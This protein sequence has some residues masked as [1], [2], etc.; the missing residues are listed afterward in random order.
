LQDFRAICEVYKLKVATEK[1]FHIQFIIEDDSD[2]SRWNGKILIDHQELMKDKRK[3][4]IDGITY[5]LVK[6]TRP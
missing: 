1:Y 3:R 5:V 6:K 2:R 4:F